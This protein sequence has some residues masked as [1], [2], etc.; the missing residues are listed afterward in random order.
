MKKLIRFLIIWLFRIEYEKYKN[1]ILRYDKEMKRIAQ[2]RFSY[3]RA[4]DQ[5]YIDAKR[6]RDLLGNIDISVDVHHRSSSWAV[7]SLQ[8]QK[9]DYIRF[10][11][12]SDSDIR[13]IGSFLRQFDQEN[14]KIDSDIPT[15]NVI[16]KDVFRINRF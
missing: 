3:E 16:L 2:L 1:V 4:I 15:R 12:L 14:I 8:G 7:I 5:A 9:Q 6:I 11:H 13:S 10:I